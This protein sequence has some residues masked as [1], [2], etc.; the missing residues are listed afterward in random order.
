VLPHATLLFGRGPLAWAV[1][2]ATA[3]LAVVATYRVCPRS[4]DPAERAAIITTG[5]MLAFPYLFFYD[6][7]MVTLAVG[8][9]AQSR[10]LARLEA[11]VLASLAVTPLLVISGIPM[12]APGVIL[13]A[14]LVLWRRIERDTRPR[15]PHPPA[16]VR[17]PAPAVAP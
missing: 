10:P 7:P 3:T 17:T 1:Q 11:A 16:E 6:L 12:L 14:F 9:Y 15:A 5:T 8:L 13:A 2:A 4:S